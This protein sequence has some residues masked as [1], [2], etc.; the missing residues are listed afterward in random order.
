MSNQTIGLLLIV[1]GIALAILGVVV[2]LGGL[3]WFGQLPGDIRV[4][5]ETVRLYVPITSMVIL[6][7][8]LILILYVVRRFR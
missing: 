2:R 4:E 7:L 8:A 6:S 1:T 3:R 5:R